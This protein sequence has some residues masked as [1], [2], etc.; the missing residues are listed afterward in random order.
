MQ[1]HKKKK[2][3]D[4]HVDE[5]WLIPYADL[6]TLL[7]ALFIVLFAMS[8][9]DERKASQL[10]HSLRVAFQGG[11]GVLHFE[12]PIQPLIPVSDKDKA[13]VTSSNNVSEPVTE[14][15]R[16][17]QEETLQLTELAKRLNQYMD[18]NNLKGAL[19]TEVSEQ[20]LKITIEEKALFNSGKAEMLPE[21]KKLAKQISSLL[22]EVPSREITI[23][24]HTDNLPI[25]TREFKSNWELSSARANNFLHVVLENEQL[26]KSNFKTAGY[27]E[28]RPITD[29]STSEGR[30]KNRRVEVLIERIYNKYE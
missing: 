18:Q 6:L 25:K 12:N 26:D 10:S 5:T 1:R 14:A 20:G 4:E 8:Q 2:H 9:V 29:N 23:S 15:N 3:H 30:A 13:S 19:M 21:A 24:G 7:L 11:A 17:Y 16:K 28:N 22:E 27:A